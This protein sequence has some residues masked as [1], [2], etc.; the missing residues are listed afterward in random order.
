[1]ASK[2]KS[3]EQRRKGRTPKRSKIGNTIG[4]RVPFNC[5]S[6]IFKKHAFRI[7]PQHSS[8]LLNHPMKRKWACSRE[9]EVFYGGSRNTSDLPVVTLKQRKLR[10]AARGHTETDGQT[11][12]SWAARSGQVTLGTA[13]TTLP[14]QYRFSMRQLKT[15]YIYT[16][17]RK[18]Q[19]V[20]ADGGRTRR[21][22]RPLNRHRG[23]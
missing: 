23:R 20:S 7:S 22:S 19:R 6:E 3:L 9:E 21:S 2:V 4:W 10:T 5:N 12:K 8:S 18:S 17:R 16:Q 13:V 14:L 15:F 1:L 11:A